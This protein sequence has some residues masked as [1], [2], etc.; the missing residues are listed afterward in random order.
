MSIP[1][2]PGPPPQEPQGPY[3]PGQYAHGQH[4]Q[5]PCA[6]P[7]PYPYQPWGQGY[8]PYNSPAPV[9]GVAIAALALGILCCVPAL[10]LLLGLVALRQIRRS[11]ER[12]RGMAVTGAVLS[13]LG[14][15]L[16][17]AVPVG[18]AALDAWLKN[19]AHDHGSAYSLA[20]GECFDS[21]SGSL[22]GMAYDVDKVPCAGLHDAEV[23]ATFRMAG[24]TRY[25][26]D[27]KVTDAADTRC[28]ALRYGY[29]MDAWAVPD[30]VDVYYLTP[31]RQSWRYGDREVTCLFGN[32]D[33]KAGLKGSLRNDKQTL[34]ADQAAY[35]KAADVENAALDR[36]PK[37]SPDDDLKAGRQW[38]GRM[39]AAL[40][41]EARM[42]RGHSWP[43]DAKAPVAKVVKEVT[44]RQEEWA[45]AAKADD[46]NSFYEHY[47]LVMALSTPDRAVTA[48][49]ALGLTAVP[50]ESRDEEDDGNGTG[51][52]SE[53]E[54]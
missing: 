14:L 2:P 8:R 26:G 36:Q 13:C 47:D 44:A 6:P 7:G 10:G 9:N 5:G 33:E 28:Y 12:G 30:D 24:G 49:K 54:V 34:D 50:P 46:A 52:S 25:P 22:E 15:V 16:W 27:G 31:G 38:A 23:F 40:T 29:A 39:S 53:F 43:A 48:R 19:A 20:K 4:P 3:P 17:V 37:D 18:G 41:E 42:L 32:T 11:G 35:L 1:P 45:R 21:P 51:G